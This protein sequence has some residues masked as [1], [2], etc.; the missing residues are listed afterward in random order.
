MNESSMLFA[1]K[2]TR[3]LNEYKSFQLKSCNTNLIVLSSIKMDLRAINL[4]IDP[5][6]ANV[7]VRF[8]F[9]IYFVS[10]KALT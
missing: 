10:L 5:E 8:I 3:K 9:R 1:L 7:N 2:G 4:H 6:Y